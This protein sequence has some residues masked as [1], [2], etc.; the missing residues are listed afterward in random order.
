ML[1]RWIVRRPLDW[2]KRSLPGDAAP[3]LLLDFLP[4]TVFER[5]RA[6]AQCQQR[7]CERNRKGLHLLIL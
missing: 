7:N 6:A 3:E 5:V 1:R 2:P 4:A